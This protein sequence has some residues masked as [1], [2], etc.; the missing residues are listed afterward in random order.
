MVFRTGQRMRKK[1]EKEGWKGSSRKIKT[2]GGPRRK[3]YGKAVGRT[4][5]KKER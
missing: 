5:I 3:A 1:R 4:K 2:R